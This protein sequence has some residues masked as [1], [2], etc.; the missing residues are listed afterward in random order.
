LKELSTDAKKAGMVVNA[1]GK[2]IEE[3]I[4]ELFEKTEFTFEKYG[5]HNSILIIPP[6]LIGK[7]CSKIHFRLIYNVDFFEMNVKVKL[8]TI[9]L[10]FLL[11]FL[12][13]HTSLNFKETELIQYRNPV[14]FGP[15][16]KTCPKC[17]PHLLQSTSSRDI[18]KLRSV[19]VETFSDFRGEW[20]LGHPVPELNLASELNKG[21]PQPAQ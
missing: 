15:S 7:K 14:G 2:S 9:F 1:K 12:K 13:F 18:P 20:K 16:S 5:N 3:T 10:K 19:S 21:A 4:L 17:P 6:D 11:F 8:F